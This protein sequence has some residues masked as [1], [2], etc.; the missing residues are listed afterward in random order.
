M[1][2][3]LPIESTDEGIVIV[4]NDEQSLNVPSSIELSE[5]GSSNETSDNEEHPQKELSPIFFTDE[6]IEIFDNEE[7][8]L[9][10]SFPI[11]VREEGNV[12]STNDE[13]YWKDDI[14]INFT[15]E[16]IMTWRNDE[17]L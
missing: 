17:Q 15:E 3:K 12:I 14:P 8:P 11:E 4:A 2:A 9:N 5:Q 7:Q 13:Q 1:N 6:G 16:G 10:E